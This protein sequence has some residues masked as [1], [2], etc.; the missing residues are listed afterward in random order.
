MANAMAKTGMG[1]HS[2]EMLV[3]RVLGGD[4]EAFRTLVEHYETTVAGVVFGMVGPGAD[5]DDIG[6]EVMMKLYAA[7]GGF[8]GEASLKTFVTR[9]AINHCLDHLKKRK[10]FFRRFRALDY[11][12]DHALVG[13]VDSGKQA[14]ERQ[15]I[16]RALMNLPVPFRSVIVLRLIE[17][18]STSETAAILGMPEGTILSRLARAKKQMA[19]QLE[20]Y[21]HG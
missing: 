3:A 17:G 9:I 20:D 2:D 19:A 12:M 15:A 1:T 13:L 18:H 7:L 5:A 11:E 21:K 6:Q 10:R 16:G 8:R 4:T 14:E